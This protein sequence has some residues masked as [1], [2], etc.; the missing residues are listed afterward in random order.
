[1]KFF[2]KSAVSLFSGIAILFVSI[3]FLG[4][5]IYF[6]MNYF[7]SLEDTQKMKNNRDALSLINNTLLEL[8]DLGVGSYKEITIDVTDMIIIDH[9]ENK[10]KITQRMNNPKSIDRLKDEFT[11]GSLKISKELD[12]LVYFI[13]YQDTLSF[14]NSLSLLL[15]DKIRFKIIDVNNNKPLISIVRTKDPFVVEEINNTQLRFLNNYPIDLEIES[16]IIESNLLNNQLLNNRIYL[17]E[18]VLINRAN[19]NEIE[20]ACLPEKVFLLRLFTTD[21]REVVTTVSTNEHNLIKCLDYGTLVGHWKIDEGEGTVAYD[22][23]DNE[24]HG[25][26][27]GN[28]FWLKGVY[29]D[30]DILSFD[31]SDDYIVIPEISFTKDDSWSF[32][33]WQ[34]KPIDSASSWQ[35]FIGNILS[36]SGGYWMWHPRLTWYQV[37]NSS[38]STYYGIISGNQYNLLT[39]GTDIDYGE[40]FYLTIS[41]NGDTK[42][43][44]AYIN[45][46][47]IEK[48]T[49]NW[50]PNSD[51]FKFKFIGKGDYVRYF[52]GYLSD[53]QIYD[54][55]L[56]SQEINAIY[57]YTVN[58]YIPKFNAVIES[59]L[60]NSSFNLNEAISFSGVGMY[61]N[62]DYTCSWSSSI[63]GNIG[64]ECIF[65]KSDLS[66]GE[67]T[68][69][70]EVTDQSETKQTDINIIV[71]GQKTLTLSK[72][73]TG[74]G[75][76][77][78][79]PSGINCGETCSAS[80]E[81]GTSVTLTA[82]VSTGNVFTGWSGEGCSGTGTCV[83][84]M[85]QARNVTANFDIDYC[86]LISNNLPSA[87]GSISGAGSYQC[88]TAVTLTASPNT[89]YNFNNW[90]NSGGTQLSTNNPY[91]FTLS[92]SMT[93]NANYNFNEYTLTLLRE[94][95]AGGTVSGAGT[96]EYQSSVTAIATPAN[97]Y[98]FENWTDEG[99]NVVST[100]ASYTFNM[101][102]ENRTL[103]ANF[104]INS[105]ALT[106][107]KTGT[108]SGTVTS[109]PSGVNC[110]STCSYD[111]EHGTSVT[112]TASTSTGNVFTGW[113][114]E[115]CSGTGTCVVSMTQARNVTANF[116]EE[117]QQYVLADGGEV[118]DIEISGQWYR[119]HAFKTIGSNTL[120]VTQGGKVDVLVVAGGG[121]G[122]GRFTTTGG[123]G[124]GGLI[125]E[126]NLSL[127][128]NNYNIIIGDGGAAVPSTSASQGN[129]G[130]NS[131]FD[132]LTAIGGGG[133]AA[134]STNTSYING[135]YGGSGGGASGRLSGGVPGLGESNQGNHGGY[136]YNIDESPNNNEAGGGGGGAG[137]L[138][139][140][141]SL[142]SGGIG[143]EGL[144]FGNIFTD[145]YGNNGW[146]SK[147]GKGGDR[148]TNPSSNGEN[149]T[150]NGGEGSGG[151]TATNSGAGGSGI[152]L[153][154]YKLETTPNYTLTVSKTG[155]GEGTVTSSPSGIDCGGTCSY[156]YEH[157]TSVTLTASTSTG[158]VFTGWSGEGCSGTGTCTVSMTQARNVTANF[159]IDYCT[160]TS[161]NLPS[162]GG[163]ISGAGSYQCGT[164][165]TLTATPNT[166]YN[167]SNWTNSGGTQLSTNNP[168]MFTLSSSMT[169][170]ANYNF[171]EYTLTLLREPSAG[172]TVSGAG[173]YEYQSSVTAIAT[174]A[175]G[176]HFVNWT[177]ALDNVVSTNASYTFNMPAENRTLVA[178]FLIN[179]YALTVS[180]TGAG[181]G[182][183][184]S[185]PSGINCGS[186]CS[187]SYEHG[188]SV[189]LTA[190][191]STGNVFTGWSG[192]GCSGTGT[193][194]VSMTQARNV[195]ANFDIDYCTLTSSNLPSAGGAISGAGS[196]QCGSAVTLT[197]TPNTGYNFSKWTNSGGTQLST[198]NPYMFTLSSSMTVNANYN[199]N[200]YTLTL[201]RDP[202][203]GG[204]VSGAGTYAYQSSVTA[205]A[206][207]ATGYTFVNW[208]DEGDNVVSTDSS[209]TFN[210]PAENKTLVANF[211][212]NLIISILS[213]ES[214]SIFSYGE[215]IN[216][217][218]SV[219][220]NIGDY[221]CSWTSDVYGS[222]GDGCDFTYDNKNN[223]NGS[224]GDITIST[225]KNINTDIL[226]SGRTH[227]DGIITSVS[228]LSDSSAT[229]ASTEGISTDDKVLLINLQGTTG[230]NVGNYELLEVLNVS[231]NIINF[232]SVIKKIYGATSNSD[233]SNQKIVLQRV[234][235]YNNVTILNGG[236]LT[237]NAWDGTTGGIIAFMTKESLIINTGG[238]ID[239]SEK[240]LRGGQGS[241]SGYCKYGYNGEGINQPNRILEGNFNTGGGQGGKSDDSWCVTGLSPHSPM[242]GGG[243]SYGTKG[244]NGSNNGFSGNIY[245]DDSLN[246]IY[247]GSGG[248]GSS[249]YRHS[250]GS[251]SGGAGG[252]GGGIIL[253]FTDTINNNGTI[254]SSG[255][256]GANHITHGGGGGG[257]SG[258]SVKIFS[259]NK[260]LIGS[261]NILGGSGGTGY[262]GHIGGSGGQGM[263]KINTSGILSTG[264]HTIN[265]SVTDQEETKT[266]DVNITVEDVTEMNIA[267][268][269]PVNDSNLFYGQNINFLASVDNNTGEHTCSWTSDV[270]GNLNLS[271]V[272]A[273]GG[274][275][276]D[277]QI[278]GEWYRI[279]AFKD[280]GEDSFNVTQGGE[281]D[282][283]VVAG[284]GG[285]GDKYGG[286]GG[287]GGLLSSFTNQ[288]KMNVFFGNYNVF[289]GAG[290]SINSS[291]SN[292]QFNN[293]IA[294]GGGRGHS[295]RGNGF[296]GG[297]GG[298][299]A[300][301]F[302]SSY[303]LGGSGIFE[304]GMNGGNATTGRGGGG[305]GFLQSGQDGVSGGM[306]GG[307]GINLSNFIGTSFG[308]NGWF[309]GG[310]GGGARH[311]TQSGIGGLGGGGGYSKGYSN[312]MPNTGGGGSAANSD[313][314]IPRG[315]G[316]S[317]IVL[318]RYQIPYENYSSQDIDNC[319]INLSSLSS[320][321][322]TITLSVTDQEETKTTDV[323][324]TIEEPLYPQ[325]Y[326]DYLSLVSSDGGEVIDEEETLSMFEFL[327]D[328][329]LYNN[330]VL[331][332]SSSTGV[333]TRSSGEDLFI[334]KAYDF[335]GNNNHATQ[336]TTTDQ[337]KLDNLGMK[338]DGS[339]DYL[340]INSVAS[341]ITG[342]STSFFTWIKTSDQTGQSIISVN[343]STG[344]NVA[345]FWAY[346]GKIGL[347]DGAWNIGT[348][349]ITN[350]IWH[351]VGY[352]Y[353]HS[354]GD[355]VFYVDGQID[356]ELS[357]S[358]SY[359]STDL[360]S[361]GQEW[362]NSSTSDHFIGKIENSTIFNKVLSP[363]EITALYNHT[364]DKYAI[365]SKYLEF[366]GI[367]DYVVVENPPSIPDA[368]N[369]LT[370][371]YWMR[372]K[373]FSNDW[374][375]VLHSHSDA[376]GTSVGGSVVWGGLTNENKICLTIGGVDGGHSDGLINLVPEINTWYH[377][378][379]AWD[380]SEVK[381]YLNGNLET[382]YQRSS[383]TSAL[384]PIH[385]GSHSSGGGY[386]SF[387][388]DIEDVRI[389][390]RALT[391]QEIQDT[392]ITELQGNE[393]GLIG[394]WKF[395][396]DVGGLAIDSTS[397]EN[398]GIIYGATKKP[399][400]LKYLSFDGVDDYVNMG[401]QDEFDF[402]SNDFTVSA[403]ALRPVQGNDWSRSIVTKWNTGSS[404]GTNE[405]ILSL[406][407]GGATGVQ[408]S[409]SI[410][411]DIN[412]YTVRSPYNST[413][414]NW[415]HL[416]GIREGE[417][418]KLYVNGDLKDSTYIGNIAV[419]NVGRE[420]L[421]AKI[422]P[423]YNFNGLI[424]DVRIYNRALTQQEIKE[425]MT[426]ELIGNETGLVGY[427]KF[428]ED[429]GSIANDETTNNNHGTIYGVTRVNEDLISSGLILNLDAGNPGSY[430][431]TGTFWYDISGNGYNAYGATSNTS[432]NTPA[433]FPTWEGNNGGRFYFDGSKGLNIA[434]NM[435]SY[436]LGTHEICLYRA[437][438][439]S[440]S[441]YIADAR[442]SGGN[443]W[444]TNYVSYNINIHSALQVNN[445][446]TYQHDS[447]L[448][449]RWICIV[450]TS[451]SSGSKFYV[452]GEEITDSRIIKSSPLN[453]NLGSNFRIATRYTFSGGW[454][455]YIANYRIYNRVLSDSEILQNYN[456]FK[457]RFE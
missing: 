381:V 296:D 77:T 244:T 266:T 341:N 315:T 12:S 369:K 276:T 456:V 404:P 65:S 32:S 375:Y 226:S 395:N 393:A 325:E 264:E 214:N 78:S 329:G 386:R 240:G 227:A 48:K 298:G 423:G 288:E 190:A 140:N 272:S 152:V 2:K 372:A 74:E 194:V 394:Y 27:F 283:L 134:Q 126:N 371:S 130:E 69:T 300:S 198:N 415:Y 299:A 447:N 278:S 83:V 188:T 150:G 317:G 167:F 358:I 383:L 80:Y 107:S 25:E 247:L 452:N 332:V 290:G 335:S 236:I 191:T 108:G 439:G 109:S 259:K 30:L 359:S 175:T 133:G 235:Q 437:D 9:V 160:L 184:T 164:A 256:N 342:N 356:K 286:G 281:V 231:G 144:Y 151:A 5:F 297:S 303:W 292:S 73:G 117:I 96:Y 148:Y 113:S 146:F 413:I 245:G 131:I 79:S 62:G 111:Y 430:P 114:G 425:N 53:V 327:I 269:S 239:V 87:G 370:V 15:E 388:V 253:I 310:G 291:G 346:Q 76:V 451:N 417:Y 210:M 367:D 105:Y 185:S 254:S 42:E 324:I 284:G 34:Y 75:A 306:K 16:Y 445:P 8:K 157:G 179:S 192:E 54:R 138:G 343:T 344:G 66:V 438:T 57:D 71:E 336:T 168:Y 334:E 399:E 318:V 392:M 193:C 180:K 304:Q 403:W 85:T 145:I 153:V 45:G 387:N 39:L 3:I 103:V 376:A 100:D 204:S 316:G 6:A 241:S 37:Y 248:G 262:V 118:T 38:T 323:N 173:T 116:D 26:I 265:L 287:A 435:G 420:L 352:T 186:T 68:I 257:G 330:L 169:V 29:G 250:S 205:T 234:P 22:L 218:A 202:S 95:S 400:P 285:G 147:G 44:L 122:G 289:V 379:A 406:G 326:L 401:D 354:N 90:T 125:F 426:T 331:G 432:T 155:T 41:Y 412:S 51:L 302:D 70:L 97:Y 328:N 35:G 378:S 50:N 17:T 255:A 182:T 301:D 382:T 216:F 421:I 224:D 446:S 440:S 163:S 209:Y 396:E 280:V 63:N 398:H 47:F 158:N 353:N 159:D 33:T 132:N 21:G 350:G 450:I 94:P 345:L 1:M 18:P 221:T 436:S 416:A 56:S 377:V 384:S 402:G 321:E 24:N 212:P 46:N 206:T 357:K 228:S 223:G 373:S 453:M 233:L 408:P 211:R 252:N 81:H 23:S 207:P 121:S 161:N 385:L 43:A 170:N 176:Y 391:Q 457:N 196:Y 442:N 11:L 225:T 55:E 59:P 49:V 31:G 172:G 434:Q 14:N 338:F 13:D 312:G 348:K 232:T 351:H 199:Y 267:I 162:A 361:I 215:E 142:N 28:P 397:N 380:G 294:M 274:E 143:G 88:G 101:P 52:E 82:S 251:G 314:S 60:N 409:F 129:D 230:N 242:S 246:K 455:G 200:E 319:D 61:S 322:H 156:D 333:K 454:L 293:V 201:L 410:Q 92:S 20:I 431:E 195:T 275:V 178:N 72:T 104:L 349:T 84:S 208:T 305:G 260:T 137:G 58:N 91:M 427:W 141:A 183:V 418:I 261:I 340:E 389:Y 368:S 347:H 448:W 139:Q 308:E 362:D 444:L 189:T 19:T 433:N 237:S 4:I 135:R 229:V 243:G 422:N 419:N 363:E 429:T 360:I 414:N 197:A 171:N 313:Y 127:E 258:G 136:G 238:K 166:G 67:H 177:D 390:N 282:F 364:K 110:G 279:H 99:D 112:L 339:D 93:V 222:L 407:G 119:I 213:P 309:A 295:W 102:A 411:S 89:G 217:L 405:W 443:W 165:V 270:D 36:S 273:E 98:I 120:N 154:R 10:I 277:T 355:T 106:V 64:E 374:Q 219:E 115:G 449:N 249:S 7:G 428:N 366:D 187:A 263:S 203:A 174:P 320:G 40:W 365:T 123:G 181:E 271:Y 441:R 220:N 124:A 149:N 128:I 268:L 86:T 337:P 311:S 424:D 307:D